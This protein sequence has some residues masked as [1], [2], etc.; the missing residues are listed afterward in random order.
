MMDMM[1][2]T[3]NDG[4]ELC[5]GVAYLISQL[6]YLAQMAHRESTAN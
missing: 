6:S 1:V 2:T 3:S 4:D 5:I